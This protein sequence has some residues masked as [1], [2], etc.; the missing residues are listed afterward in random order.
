VN[1]SNHQTRVGADVGTSL[2]KIAIRRG[3]EPLR[4]ELAPAEAIERVA[5]EVESIRPERIGVTG[6]GATRLADLV[7]LDTTPIGEFDAWSAGAR[8]LLRRQGAA[9][10]GPF[11]LVS[12]GTGTS[13]LLVET[14]PCASADGPRGDLL[15]PRRSHRSG[16]FENISD[17]RAGDRGASSS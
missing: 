14:P 8:E 11:L 10:D 17:G 15:G 7:R 16:G 1:P 13:V 3:D 5:R 12:L 2:A 6:A 9:P 4:L